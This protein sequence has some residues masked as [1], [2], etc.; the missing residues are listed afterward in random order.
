M[1]YLLHLVKVY[2]S[3]V[4]LMFASEKVKKENTYTR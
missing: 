3:T 4:E 1:K 2:N